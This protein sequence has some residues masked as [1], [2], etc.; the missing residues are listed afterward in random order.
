MGNEPHT[1][2]STS[3]SSS[4]NPSKRGCEFVHLH[5]HSEYSL[6]SSLVKMEKLVEKVASFG[7]PAVALTDWGNLYGALAF[8]KACKSVADGAVRPIF[9]V[10][11][12]VVGLEGSGP[13]AR[14]LTLLAENNLGFE[15]LSKIVT[16]S[17]L[18]YGL[19]GEVLRPKIPLEELVKNKDGIIVLTGGAKGLV[20]SFLVQ[21]QESLAQ[22]HLEFLFQHFGKENLFIELQDHSLSPWIRAQER[23]LEWARDLDLKP[24]ATCD[25]H[26]LD[27]SEATAQEVWMMVSQKLTL[28]E[29]PLSHLA[30]K[31]F[32]LRSPDEMKESYSDNPAALK[33]TVEIADRCQVKLSFKDKSGKRIF[34]LPNF[35]AEGAS[36]E[37]LFACSAREGLEKKF[38]LFE[39][40]Q[41]KVDRTPYLERLEYEI[42]TIQ[43]MGFSGYYLIVSDFIRWAKS[44][45]IPVGPGRGSGAGSLAAY[46]LDITDLDPIEHGLLF[47]RF[48]NPERVS[49]PDFD[50]DFCQERRFEVIKYVTEKYGKDRVCQIVTFAKEQSKNALKDVGRVLGLSFSETNRLT[51]LIPSVQAKPLTIAE[52]LE[53]VAE[54]KSVVESDNKVK[55]CVD[56]ALK[57]EGA[58]RQP[59][60]HAAGV[61]ISSKPV[62]EV[63]PLS[64]D[65]EGHTLTQWDMKMS[66]EAGLVKFDF[67]GL[68][69]LDLM[70]LACRWIRKR[71]EPESQN[72]YYHNVPI[73]DPRSY[74]LIASGDTMGVFQLESSGMQNLCTRMKPDRFADI[75]AINALFRPG[76]LQAG[77]VDDF[78]N[79]KHGRAKVEV[80]FPE[81]DACLKETYG[82]IIYQEQ[83]MEIARLVSGY[84]LGGADL[85]RR[86]MGKK[87]AKEMDAQRAFFV[88]GAVKNGKPAQKAGE[89]FDLIEKF[90]G[91]GFN[92]SHAA[93]YAFLAVQT[94]FLKSVYPTEFFTALLTIEKQDTEK[95]SRY[96]AD[97][98]SRGLKI[99]PPDINESLSDFSI[100]SEGVIRFGL[101]AIKNVGES[102]VEAVLD[103]RAALKGEKFKD[104]FDFVSKVDTRRVNKRMCEALIQ[105]G[106]FDSCEENTAR[107]RGKYLA[108]LEKALEWASKQA[109]QKEEGQFS[110]FGE[111]SSGSVDM[112]RPQYEI[113]QQL[114]STRQVL[115]WEK[116]LLGI[117][118][119]GSPL[120]KYRDRAKSSG[121][122]AIF[123]LQE[124]P[125]KTPIVI[126]G[127]VSDLREV[128]V[129]KG[130]RAGELMAILKIEDHSGQVELISFPDHYKEFSALF[131]STNPLLIR[132]NLEFEEDRPKL[133]CGDV[134]YGGGLAVEDLSLIE[135]KW[136]KKLRLHVGLKSMTGT[137]SPQHLFVEV[138]KILKKFPGTV[139]VELIMKDQGSFQ[140]QI[141]LGEKFKVNPAKD[142][143][144]ELSNM[145][146]VPG[147]M[148][149]ETVL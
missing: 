93:A 5:V 32:F 49:L 91:Y 8:Y 86:A 17:H 137:I 73:H 145:V 124:K 81:M 103:A 120:D 53:Q 29:N 55:Q 60:I 138:S 26:Y 70:D 88:D 128:R 69:T 133:M 98:K 79:R 57:I 134:T 34:H 114:P 33:S 77:M 72:L 19:E 108:T 125:P 82:V 122:I 94:A 47:E 84:T 20:N 28:D 123:D 144:N 147:A 45:D 65:Q 139:P 80:M 1:N 68:V 24:A 52:T 107:L 36:E 31:E 59:G 113:P 6:S 74:A 132:A 148:T 37:E 146:S 99:L 13:F 30:P 76:P 85:L 39:T 22:K 101:S 105:A 130:R 104:L 63:A 126:T 140:T 111:V 14:H 110:L 48:L 92:K 127:L 87:N 42:K 40:L 56:L 116:E 121:A 58:L 136:P 51:K 118:L 35:S 83:V 16:R 2:V 41:K 106:A 135:E 117:F 112:T 44:H 78:I 50:V 10:E 100:V 119:T 43:G 109:A 27:Q 21:D 75:A 129:K 66:E 67:L 90:A 23:L 64:V 142:L 11:M 149:V 97:A 89:L 115:D 96:I 18:E 102:G 71:P 61:I 25:V 143:V 9:G 4:V 131:K 3:L 141:D 62:A 7:M 15:N 95:L 54:F 38:S 46:V 12:G